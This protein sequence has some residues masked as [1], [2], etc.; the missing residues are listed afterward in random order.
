MLLKTVCDFHDCLCFLL[1][2][3]RCFKED[4]LAA[5]WLKA[6][7]PTICFLWK[8]FIVFII[9]ESYLAS[10]KWP[11]I[12]PSSETKYHLLM[13]RVSGVSW[14]WKINLYWVCCSVNLA[15]YIF[16]FIDCKFKFTLSSFKKVRFYRNT[17]NC[18]ILYIKALVFLF[19]SYQDRQEKELWAFSF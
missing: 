14:A 9:V 13:K 17:S 18:S 2:N 8:K 5:C 11:F 12:S 6:F 7:N 15:L 3:L 16:C 1:W 19:I 10:L 4:C